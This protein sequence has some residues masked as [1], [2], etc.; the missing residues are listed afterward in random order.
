MRFTKF[1]TLEIPV[2][3]KKRSMEQ[4]YQEK[5]IKKL[6]DQYGI[7]DRQTSNFGSTSFGQI[8]SDLSIS[9]SQLTKLIYGTATEGMYIRSIQNVDRLLEVDHL[10][11]ELISLTE[12]QN[13]LNQ[14]LAL[15]NRQKR[16][17]RN[18]RPW[19]AAGSFL[20]GGLLFFL[21][22]GKKEA[23]V[24]PISP[25]HPLSTYFDF[26]FAQESAF[27]SPYLKE[28]EVQ[29]YCPGSAYEGIW[30]LEKPYK[31]PIPD[32]KPGLYYLAKSADVRMKVAR[33]NLTYGKG[34][35]LFAYEYLVNEIWLDTKRTPLSPKYFNNN[36]KQ[37]TKAFESLNFEENPE[38]KR[39]ATV[40]SFFISTIEIHNDSITRLGEPNGRYVSNVDKNLVRK[41]NIDLSHLLENVLSDLTKTE[42]ANIPN[43][44]C[45]PNALKEKESV[46]SFDCLYTIRSEN[47]GIGGGYP[48]RKGF[49]LEKQI[50]AN[51]LTC[52][53][54]QEN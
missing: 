51:N 50:Y 54:Q 42:C 30:S 37:Y 31:L 12:Q 35:V 39:V 20:L 18:L 44:F 47:L 21:A 1:Y 40:H 26:E 52:S 16:R 13:I 32:K 34:N 45:D 22:F 10:K 3:I 14:D 48:Y 23:S 27:Q 24:N 17:W 6:E 53:C 2:R 7:W 33:N 36:S 4:S 43:P 5:F 38:F 15:C 29:D 9:N 49:R 41:Y 25:K 11:G 28:S 8:A 19:M 46:L